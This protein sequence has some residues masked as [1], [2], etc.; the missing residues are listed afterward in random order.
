VSKPESI[1]SD[2]A[3]PRAPVPFSKRSGGQK[4]DVTIF[5]IRKIHFRPSKELGQACCPEVK[6]GSVRVRMLASRPVL[7]RFAANQIKARRGPY[8]PLFSGYNLTLLKG[9]FP[10]ESSCSGALLTLSACL[11]QDP[12]SVSNFLGFLRTRCGLL[13]C[14]RYRVRQEL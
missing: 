14:R 4:V 6:R 8:L 12:D 2:E 13:H 1:R 9:M 10:Q 7:I 11:L 5:W 3:K